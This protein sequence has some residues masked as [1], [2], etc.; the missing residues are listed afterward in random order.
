MK[1]TALGEFQE[2]ILLTILILEENTYGVSIQQE[3]AKRLDKEVSRGSLHTAL[4]RLADKKFI[5]SAFGEA[6]AC[7]LYTS[8]AADE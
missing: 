6:S 1:E 3:I 4:S 2:I 7:L 5:T 8:D